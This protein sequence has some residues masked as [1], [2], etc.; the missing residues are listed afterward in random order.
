MHPNMHLQNA[1]PKSDGLSNPATALLP[2]L[3]H[4]DETQEQRSRLGCAAS[5]H[6]RL[7]Q[8]PG[9]VADGRLAIDTNHALGVA[10]NGEISTPV[11]G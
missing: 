11:S 7:R 9:T 1:C 8:A 5:L 10:D 3:S 2:D 6:G 4:S